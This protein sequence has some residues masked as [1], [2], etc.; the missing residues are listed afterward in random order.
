MLQ[1]TEVETEWLFNKHMNRI[2]H[3]IAYGDAAVENVSILTLCGSLTKASFSPC[4]F[5][6]F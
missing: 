2:E 5:T 4:S 3:F 1:N 6:D